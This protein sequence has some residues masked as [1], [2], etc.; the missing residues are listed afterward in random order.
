MVRTRDNNTYSGNG[1]RYFNAVPL[2]ATARYYYGEGNDLIPCIGAG[3][4]TIYRC[5]DIRMGDYDF[6]RQGWQLGLFPEEG[7]QY[8]I[9]QR[10][11]LSANAR[12]NYS[13]QN[14]NT[15]RSSFLNGAVGLIYSY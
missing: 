3:V 12:Y 9:G 8:P 13:F 15:A 11:R 1:Y 7:V 6:H 5:H 10:V 4:G 2:F 14:G